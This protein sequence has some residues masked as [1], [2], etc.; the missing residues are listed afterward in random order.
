[1]SDEDT[2]IDIAALTGAQ[3]MAA[4]PEKPPV[5]PEK[6]SAPRRLV[7]ETYTFTMQV[8]D[9]KTGEMQELSVVSRVYG[10]NDEQR[11]TNL[12]CTWS[13]DTFGNFIP[14]DIYAADD[15]QTMRIKARCLVQCRN[16]YD[17]KGQPTE[18]GRILVP[19]I[20]NDAGTRNALFRRL[21]LH[22]ATFRPADRRSARQQLAEGDGDKVQPRVVVSPWEFAE[23]LPA[24]PGRPDAAG[25]EG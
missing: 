25:A 9:A 23:Q 15:L 17:D 2:T 19:L 22:E 3:L 12:V 18:T 13:K 11:A 16:L 5:A 8:E 1:M 20:H 10:G 7:P 6:R 4:V 21:A 24:E 14:L